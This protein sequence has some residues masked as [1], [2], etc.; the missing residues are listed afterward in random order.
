MKGLCLHCSDSHP[1]C[2]KMVFKYL[3]LRSYSE[4]SLEGRTWVPVPYQD[5]EDS[6]PTYFRIRHKEI[7]FKLSF[8]SPT[9]AL[10]LQSLMKPLLFG[11]HI[12]VCETVYLHSDA[13]DSFCRPFC[14]TTTSQRKHSFILKYLISS[15]IYIKV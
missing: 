13:A 4:F 2:Q 6:I 12:F 7:Y 1:Q 5:T 9:G 14:L 3:T 11:D 15:M 10:P 8:N